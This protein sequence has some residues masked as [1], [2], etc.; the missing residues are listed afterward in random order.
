MGAKILS[1]EERLR[2]LDRTQDIR[3]GLVCARCGRPDPDTGRDHDLY[4][5]E[6]YLIVFDL[7]ET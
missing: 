4:C 2:Q 6:C 7:Q 5:E 3:L 1:F